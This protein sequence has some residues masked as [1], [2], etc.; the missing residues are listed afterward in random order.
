[1]YRNI[2]LLIIVLLITLGCA[3]R[4]YITG[5]EQDIYPPE[6]LKTSPE[7]FSTNFNS[8]EI[9][10]Q[11]DEYVRLKDANTQLVVS[12]PLKYRPEIMPTNAS[13]EIKIRL[14]DTLQPNTTY[15]LNFGQSIEDNNE[16]NKLQGY[17]YVFSTGSYID[18]LSIHGYV[19]DVLDRETEPFVSVLLYE[20]NEEFNDSI[21]YKENPRYITN[22]LDSIA[23]SL[24]NIKEGNYL[25]IAL[26]DKN[27][28]NRF[29]PKQD[30]IG[31]HPE[32]IS[33]PTQ[34][35]FKLNMF[36]EIADFKPVRA[37]ESSK[38]KIVFS[39]EGNAEQTEVE[40]RKG[41]ELIETIV[42]KVQGKDSLNIW[43]RPLEADSLELK[44]Y[45]DT[46]RKD[47][48]IN[49]KEKQLDT[50]LLSMRSSKR[51]SFRENPSYY[52]TTPL[53]SFDK[54]KF[55]LLDQDSLSVDLQT[56][57]DHWNQ[58]LE[59]IFDKTE[60]Q[61]YFLTLYPGAVT[62]FFGQSNDTLR[63]DF[64]TSNYSDY[65]NLVVRLQNVKD[66]PIIVQLTDD[67]GEVLAEQ[68]SEQDSTFE[69]L[70]LNPALYNMRVIYDSNKNKIWDTGNFLRKTQPEKVIYFPEK[71]DVRANWDVEQIFI[72]R[73]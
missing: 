17:R 70:F 21:I 62:D 51:L 36:K 46:I 47:F 68:Y 64:S 13:K 26:Q 33:I 10:I 66:F 4:G 48:V 9:I 29:D 38:N 69:F 57:Y 56:K 30:K 15:S 19:K 8:S 22:T 37:F 42:T 54:T 44:V 39:H 20:V 12:P 41:S 59:L 61:K 28:N 25:L 7:N 53:V 35:T 72:L 31:F 11:F 43:Y 14:K 1:M 5:G 6:V 18:S 23:F 60:K 63:T 49:L 50:L 65:G 16:G 32:V 40:L 2:L 73:E 71:I 45:N 55:E 27:K 34:E 67:K 52:S 58:R 3:K 24:E